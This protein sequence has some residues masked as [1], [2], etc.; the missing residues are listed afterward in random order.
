M[1]SFFNLFFA[2]L[3][4]IIFIVLIN[5]PMLARAAEANHLVISELKTSGGTGKSTDE[6]IELYNPT[7]EDVNLNGWQLIKKTSAGS[8]YAL[9]D[10]FGDKTIGAHS[11]FLIV[12]PIGYL[13]SVTPDIIYSTTNSISDN[14]TIILMDPVLAAID[15]V[16]YGTTTF[17]ET[18]ATANPVAGKSLER[19]ARA[20]STIEMMVEG[21]EHYFIGNGGDS[22]NNKNDFV[23][24]DVPEPQNSSSEPEYSELAPPVIPPTPADQGPAPI[25]SKD[26]VINELFPNPKG[27]DD[28]EFIELFNT[29]DQP[30]DLNG[31]KVS[32]ATARRFII[33]SEDFKSTIIAGYGYFVIDKK[34]SGI[35]LN[36]TLDM[37][38]LYSPDDV[39]INSVD[40]NDCQEAKSYSLIDGKWVWSDEVTPG[41]PNNFVVRNELPVA[42][43]EMDGT[44][45]KVGAKISFDASDSADADDDSIVYSWNFGDG[46]EALGVKVEHSF[47]K[48]GKF[49]VR[50][51]VNDG[52]SGDDETEESV[53]ITDYDYSTK[54]VIN[55]LLPACQGADAE[56]E[57][58]ELFNPEIRSIKLEGW[59]IVIK[60][61]KYIFPISSVIKAG[62]YFVIKNNISHLT[63]NNNGAEVYLVDPRGKIINGV[64]YSKAKDDLSFSRVNN[65]SWKWTS[66]Q[67]SGKINEFDDET[68]ISDN[69]AVNTNSSLV[70]K[71]NI[72]RSSAVTPIIEATE[73]KL[74][75]TLKISAEIESTSGN[76]I[77]LVDSEG[78]S[79]RAYIQKATGIKKPELKPGDKV[80]IVGVLDK[81]TAG[82]RLLP[83]KQE[84]IVVLTPQ[85]KGQIL[86]ASTEKNI[87]DVPLKDS[88]KETKIYL[89][90]GLGATAIAVIFIVIKKKIRPANS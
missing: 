4:L 6:F 86:G 36:N 12:H 3:V 44:N 71:V 2:V 34:I 22:D 52:K 14:N 69:E 79:L 64:K 16:G 84:D 43:F 11:F 8:N 74:G 77:Y 67:T 27:A 20:D 49:V 26:I 58:I 23:L 53:V 15:E 33:T 37:S 45:M 78:N 21:G 29:S 87:T 5:L 80:E 31:W 90:F 85:E 25:Y 13:G 17:F 42:S 40:Y 73:G 47:Q 65:K 61:K 83:R 46:S 38:K 39:L 24:R 62:S 50:L 10:N 41:S 66:I 57:Y 30:V 59:Q 63:L 56:C 48:A 9:V 88:A 51:T 81:S 75:D 70:K 72:D 68:E 1:R 60:G 76:N 28:A 7:D 55:E 35:S 18:E 32:D 82:L 54:L 89:I 19:K